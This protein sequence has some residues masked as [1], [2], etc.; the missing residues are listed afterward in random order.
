[1]Y[2]TDANHLPVRI[3]ALDE[4]GAV[5]AT[6]ARFAALDGLA[7]AA[8]D[9]AARAEPRRRLRLVALTRIARRHGY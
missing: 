3:E 2:L 7:E 8:F 4:G 1:M 9:H 6:V 5:V